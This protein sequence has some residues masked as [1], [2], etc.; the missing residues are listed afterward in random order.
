MLRLAEC[1]DALE[2]AT[3]L[4]VNHLAMLVYGFTPTFI[5]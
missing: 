5:I 1:N 3:L 2:R 4:E